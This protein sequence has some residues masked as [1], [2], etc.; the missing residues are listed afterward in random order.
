MRVVD[1]RNEPFTK[2]IGRGSIY[3]NPFTY[4]PIDNTKAIVQV[5]SLDESIDEYEEWLL[6]NP[7]WAHIESE[8]RLQIIQS[9][10]EFNNN[11]V[12]GCFCRPKHRCHGDILVK[13]FNLYM[14]AE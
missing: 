5:K 8:R 7:K 1:K 11:D 4:L 12:L 9:I 13:L 14:T 6:G 10:P 3:G 2:Y